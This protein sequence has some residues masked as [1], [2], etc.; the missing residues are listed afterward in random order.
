MFLTMVLCL[1]AIIPMFL[2][3]LEKEVNVNTINLKLLFKILLKLEFP[4]KITLKL[5]K[6]LF[7]TDP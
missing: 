5:L 1:K 7:K 3:I 2:E 4:P 6:K